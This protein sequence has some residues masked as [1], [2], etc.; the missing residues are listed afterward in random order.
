MFP[1]EEALCRLLLASWLTETEI[2]NLEKTFDTGGVITWDQEYRRLSN[3]PS[4]SKLSQYLGL[5]AELRNSKG[6]TEEVGNSEIGPVS[7]DATWDEYD[8]FMQDIPIKK[9]KGNTEAAIETVV[10]LLQ[11]QISLGN[12]DHNR[13]VDE[14]LTSKYSRGYIFGS[15]DAIFQSAGVSDQVEMAALMTIVHTK[16]FGHESGGNIFGQSIRNQEDSVFVKGRNRGGQELAA[17]ISDG[18]PTMG[19]AGYLLNGE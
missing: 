1:S 15:C 4:S 19:L 3:E 5:L 11:L 8:E 17:F 18:A 14:R 12:V 2:S 10:G 16:L 6:S 7:D 13:D 9:S